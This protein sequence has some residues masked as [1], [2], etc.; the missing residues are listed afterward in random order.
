MHGE[1]ALSLEHDTFAD[2]AELVDAA[3]GRKN[4]AVSNGGVARYQ[5]TIDKHHV[6]AHR[7]IVTGVRVGEPVIVISDHSG[8]S[9]S[10]RTVHGHTLAENISIADLQIGHLRG[11][12]PVVLR[13]SSEHS[14]G[15]DH[16]I[17]PHFCVTPHH[18][19]GFQNRA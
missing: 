10:G 15:I 3:I 16:I 1:P 7:G 11:V 19:M 5:G 2:P 18:G 9:F 6:V 8:F 17:L 12:K 14:A 13:K 4:H